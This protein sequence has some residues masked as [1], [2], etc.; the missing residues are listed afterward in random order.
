MVHYKNNEI[1]KAWGLFIKT[2]D[3]SL[4]FKRLKSAVETAGISNI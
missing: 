4:A 1:I 2:N 3:D